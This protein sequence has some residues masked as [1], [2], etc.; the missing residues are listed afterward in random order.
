MKFNPKILIFLASL[1]HPL[2]ASTQV[3]LTGIDGAILHSQT[4]PNSESKFK[5][6]SIFE[7]GSETSLIK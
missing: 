1:F 7:N 4:T 2:L 5:G 3:N 6:T